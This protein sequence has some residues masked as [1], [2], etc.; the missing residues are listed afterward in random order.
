MMI[1]EPI[2]CHTF[3]PFDFSLWYVIITFF[4]DDI[5]NNLGRKNI[6]ILLFFSSKAYFC[7]THIVWKIFCDEQTHVNITVFIPFFSQSSSEPTQYRKFSESQVV[8]RESFFELFFS[9]QL[10]SR[11]FFLCNSLWVSNVINEMGLPPVEIGRWLCVHLNVILMM[12]AL[13]P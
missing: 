4:L 12:I 9:L 3:L 6:C 13:G 5:A 11:T 8:Q 7:T 1:E 10:F 2:S